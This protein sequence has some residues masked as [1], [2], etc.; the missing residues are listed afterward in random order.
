MPH[1]TSPPDL[2]DPTK[3]HHPLSEAVKDQLLFDFA[4]RKNKNLTCHQL[5][6]LRPHLYFGPNNIYRKAARNRYWYIRDNHRNNRKIFDKILDDAHARVA[7]AEFYEPP[8]TPLG[9]VPVLRMS[10]PPRRSSTTRQSAKE[11]RTPP[12]RTTSPLPPTGSPA[13]S[14]PPPTTSASSRKKTPTKKMN[15]QDTPSGKPDKYPVA[16]VVP[17]EF[18]SIKEAIEYCDYHFFV[19]FDFPEGNPHGIFVQQIKDVKL[20]DKK[21]INTIKVWWMHIGD[22]RDIVTYKYGD[23]VLR[24]RALIVYEPSVPF[25]WIKEQGKLQALEKV[26]CERSNNSMDVALTSIELNQSRWT[27]SIL[28]VFPEE[29]V[30]HPDL[31]SDVAPVTNLRIKLKM[32]ATNA[33]S[34]CFYPGFH[35]LRSVKNF[36]RLKKDSFEE[37]EDELAEMFSG[38]IMAMDED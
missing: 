35:E 30:C 36:Q 6:S 14:P 37:E 18:K 8:G 27:N 12:T 20:D 25:F 11:S 9:T 33:E 15:V 10:S 19:D 31:T 2:D 1:D 16:P 38:M 22:F 3:E 28:V 21:L 13:K 4:D 34:Q 26:P 7:E 17:P 5:L 32:R 24:G 23:L 29:E